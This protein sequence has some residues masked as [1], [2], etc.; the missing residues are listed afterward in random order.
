MEPREDIELIL[1]SHGHDFTLKTRSDDIDEDPI[2][3]QGSVT[4]ATSSVTGLYDNYNLAESLFGFGR[5][6]TGAARIFIS[7]ADS[8]DDGDRLIDST[9]TYEI[10]NV[11][12]WVFENQVAYRLLEVDKID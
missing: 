11:Q 8:V 1:N 7:G 2:Y 3:G 5:I 9:G 6:E 10:T 12:N 4:W